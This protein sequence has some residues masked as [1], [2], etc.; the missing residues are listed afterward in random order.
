[1]P[2]GMQQGET[3]VAQLLSAM[4]QRRE[5]PPGLS[6]SEVLKPEVLL[7]IFH[8]PAILQATTALSCVDIILQSVHGLFAW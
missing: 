7:P 2:A 6:L 8:D 5:Q 4:Q 1:M 3:D